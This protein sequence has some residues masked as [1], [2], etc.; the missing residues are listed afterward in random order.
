VEED[1]GER[2]NPC[3]RFR[4]RFVCLLDFRCMCERVGSALEDLYSKVLIVLYVYVQ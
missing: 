3:R 1:A 2:R 4:R